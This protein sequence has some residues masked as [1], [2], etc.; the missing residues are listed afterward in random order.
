MG[1]GEAALKEEVAGHGDDIMDGRGLEPADEGLRAPAQR[2]ELRKPGASGEVEE[3]GKGEGEKERWIEAPDAPAREATE[4]E[5]LGCGGRLHGRM[6]L[7]LA[8][9][10]AEAAD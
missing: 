4:V 8:K 3:A 1:E 2:V 9:V 10:D 5:V 7:S 6:R